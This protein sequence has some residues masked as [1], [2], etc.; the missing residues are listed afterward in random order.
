[1]SQRH[2]VTKKM[3]VTYKLL[4]DRVNEDPG[5]PTHRL[6][7][8][9]RASHPRGRGRREVSDAA[10]RSKPAIPGA[11]HGGVGPR[12]SLSRYPVG[13]RLAPKLGV[14]VVMLKRRRPR[15]H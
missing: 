14:L 5:R 3:T 2:A 4:Q 7:P 9:L 15:A 6:A 11:L 8:R 10:T 13:K 12:V 1:M